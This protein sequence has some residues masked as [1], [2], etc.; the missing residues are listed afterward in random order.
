MFIQVSRFEHAQI[1]RIFLYI[2]LFKQVF[3]DVQVLTLLGF[4]FVMT[5]LKRYGY[6][7]IGFNLLLVALVTQWSLIMRGFVESHQTHEG[8]FKIGILK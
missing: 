8:T 2:C 7:S 6:S 1:N 3:Q 5:F 4:G